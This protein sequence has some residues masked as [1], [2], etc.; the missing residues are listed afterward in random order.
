M[1]KKIICLDEITNNL[2][3]TDIHII[4]EN[5]NLKITL[6]SLYLYTYIII[7]FTHFI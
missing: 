5:V 7:Y 4:I 6:L 3:E 1:I 2:M